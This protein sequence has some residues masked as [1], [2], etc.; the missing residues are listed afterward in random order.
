MLAVKSGDARA[1]RSVVELHQSAVYRFC[2]RFLGDEAL[3]K[4]TTQDV[5]L[6]LWKHRADY[7]ERG[8]LESYLLSIA[9]RRCLAA[10]KKRRSYAGLQQQLTAAG[11]SERVAQTNLEALEAAAVIAHRLGE[12]PAQY[13]EIVILRHLEGLE[14]KEIAA[15]TGLRLGTVK[16]RLG[17]GL[18]ALRQELSDGN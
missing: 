12:M 6:T 2:L 5:F 18:A 8:K 13:A 7:D 14:L 9:R 15:V 16:S 17:R 3:A 1:F 4:D 11:A 10:V